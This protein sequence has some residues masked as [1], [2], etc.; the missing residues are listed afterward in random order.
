MATIRQKKVLKEVVK[1]GGVSV[2]KAMVKA[3]YSLS[4]AHNP[5]KLTKSRGW[6]E[7][8]DKHLPDK[9]LLKV[10]KEALK[11]TKVV[12]SMTEPDYTVV[13]HQTRLKAIE[14]AYRIK[15]K[16]DAGIS[17]SGDKVIAI[18]GGATINNATPDDG[19]TK[20]TSKQE[21]RA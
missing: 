4:T 19:D 11:A 18:L 10:H 5:Q 12:T 20:K 2:S 14:M 15:G 8:L 6:R 7:L 17:I 3:G 21:I 9:K 13:D 16:Q 1:K